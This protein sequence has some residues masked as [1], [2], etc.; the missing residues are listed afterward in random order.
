MSTSEVYLLICASCTE[1]S[2]QVAASGDSSFVKRST[3]TSHASSY[4]RFLKFTIQQEQLTVERIVKPTTV[5]GEF[6]L[7]A[8]ACMPGS[9]FIRARTFLG[10]RG[11][12]FDS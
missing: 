10:S 7:S 11:D 4:Y 3:H 9:V 6:H 8:I 5:H 1:L 2:L 12:T